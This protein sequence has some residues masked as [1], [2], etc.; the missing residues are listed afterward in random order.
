MADLSCIAS[1][2]LCGAPE[3]L[4]DTANSSA[5]GCAQGESR[6]PQQPLR[7][8]DLRSHPVGMGLGHECLDVIFR[9][10]LVAN[11]RVI[12]AIELSPTLGHQIASQYKVAVHGGARKRRS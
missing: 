5:L 8:L 12:G 11:H 3:A 4:P 6:L 2:Q 7:L 9:N 1:N 10:V